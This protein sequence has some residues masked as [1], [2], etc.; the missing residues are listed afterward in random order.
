MKKLHCVRLLLYSNS[1]LARDLLKRLMESGLQ[2]VSWM[3]ECDHPSFGKN[4]LELW[5]A[6]KTGL[7]AFRTA[8]KI[9]VLLGDVPIG[10]DINGE[11]FSKCVGFPDQ[12]VKHCCNH[13]LCWNEGGLCCLKG[14]VCV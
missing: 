5:L 10:V 2:G 6:V 1:N 9:F 14:H 3:E 7:N 4:E 12:H 13:Y 11:H 8:G